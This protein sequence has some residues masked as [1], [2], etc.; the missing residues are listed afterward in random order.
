MKETFRVVFQSENNCQQNEGIRE[1]EKKKKKLKRENGAWE[2][3]E[4]YD[5]SWGFDRLKKSSNRFF[6]FFFN[7]QSILDDVV[8]KNEIFDF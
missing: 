4:K 2:E 6:F 3:R 5:G 1:N 7:V 8:T